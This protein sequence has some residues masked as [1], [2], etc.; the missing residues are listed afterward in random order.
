MLK[1]GDYVSCRWRGGVI[2]GQ[3]VLD[4]FVGLSTPSKQFTDSVFQI[5]V[6]NRVAAAMDFEEFKARHAESQ[7][8]QV[9]PGTSAAAKN[10][11]WLITI[12]CCTRAFY[13]APRAG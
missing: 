6:R 3:G 2:E 7:R 1:I 9:R 5:G 12:T 8:V 4:D 10:A 11:H 13:D